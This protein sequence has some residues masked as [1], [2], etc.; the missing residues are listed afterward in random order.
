MWS[1]TGHRQSE[2]TTHPRST[3][4]IIA[5]FWPALGAAAEA[6]L[7]RVSGCDLLWFQAQQR[8]AIALSGAYLYVPT[9]V[10]PPPGDHLLS[11]PPQ[12]RGRQGKVRCREAAVASDRNWPT[13]VIGGCTLKRAFAAARAVS[14]RESPPLTDH[15]YDPAPCRATPPRP[16]PFSAI[17]TRRGPQGIVY[18]VSFTRHG[19]TSPSCFGRAT[20]TTHGLP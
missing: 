5:S 15:H 11:W 12:A 14:Q 4:S 10:C 17:R 3:P 1:A 16:D 7:A 6:W 9:Y 20:S 8:V 13:G 19:R 2:A 18:R